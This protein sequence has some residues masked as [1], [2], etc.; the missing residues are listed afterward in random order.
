VIKAFKMPKAIKIK[1]RTSSITNAFVNGIIPAIKPTDEEVLEALKILEQDVN[2]VRC[3]YCG[4]K[5]TEWDHLFPLVVDKKDTGYITEIKNLV[6]A[7]SKC[8]QS[9]GNKYWKD[10]MIG[11]ATQSPKNRN[12]KDLGKKIKL[13]E[14]YESWGE[15]KP[16]DLKTI[17]GE[18]LWK[19]HW[20]NY[21][22]IIK[23]IEES[24][25]VMNEIKV[26]LD[27][28]ILG[29]YKRNIN[30]KIDKPINSEVVNIENLTRD[31]IYEIVSKE[32]GK[33][34]DKKKF[35]ISNINS[36]ETWTFDIKENKEFI[37]RIIALYDNFEK[38]LHILIMNEDFVRRK[39]QEF[40]Y[41]KSKRLYYFRQNMKKGKYS[42]S[43]IDLEE[44]LVK[45]VKLEKYEDNKRLEQS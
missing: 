24:T 15:L 19:K 38:E 29:K 4:D 17:V 23:N 39:K 8:N 6:P 14:N 5:M 37:D 11:D 36:T 31:N 43:G 20:E 33:I 28:A 7:C 25:P 45:V 42:F 35:T 32:M 44:C 13:L 34:I 22:L 1:D 12:V 10:W 2:D 21:E 30:V 16:Y 18:E 40:K 41:N 26:K 9:K 3:V 27:N